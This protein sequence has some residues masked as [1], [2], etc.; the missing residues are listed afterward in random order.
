MRLAATGV[1]VYRTDSYGSIVIV[2]D[3]QSH[4]DI[5][6][7]AKTAKLRERIAGKPERLKNKGREEA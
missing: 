3:G 4:T 2:A 7:K 1:R 6:G 5:T